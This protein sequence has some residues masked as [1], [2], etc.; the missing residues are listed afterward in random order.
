[1]K[2][3]HYAGGELLTGDDIADAV[4]HYAEALARKNTSAAVEI[5]S[6]LADGSIVQVSLLLGP[7]SQLV[8]IPQPGDAE[9]ITDAE[10][11]GAFN[12]QAARLGDPAPLTSDGTP[13]FHEDDLQ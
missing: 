9:E 4:V 5:P 1:M 6:R 10:L 7:A 13:D 2:A 12:T 3:I 8:A 11:V